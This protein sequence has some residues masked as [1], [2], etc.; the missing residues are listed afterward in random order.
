MMKFKVKRVPIDTTTDHGVTFTRFMEPYL[1]K[2][3]EFGDGCFPAWFLRDH[4]G[5]ADQYLTSPACFFDD[6][7]SVRFVFHKSWLEPVKRYRV[8]L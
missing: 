3:Y 6:H 8:I 7:E 4:S 2:I 5:V 1:G